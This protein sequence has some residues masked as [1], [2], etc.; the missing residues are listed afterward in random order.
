MKVV[1]DLK[2]LLARNGLRLS[3]VAAKLYLSRPA[4]TKW[5]Q[6]G[7]PPARVPD[8]ERVTGIPR[9]LLRPDLWNAPGVQFV[10]GGARANHRAEP[11]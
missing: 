6:R 4:L 8:V 5:G 9:H 7:V 10:E 3:D 2:A 11:V 1:P